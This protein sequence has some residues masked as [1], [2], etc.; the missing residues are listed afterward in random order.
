MQSQRSHLRRFT[1]EQALARLRELDEAESGDGGDSD[2]DEDNDVIQVANCNSSSSDDEQ[3]D[4]PTDAD[5]STSL[6]V[7]T[8]DTS[9]RS[10][11]H[12]SPNCVTSRDGKNGRIYSCNLQRSLLVVFRHSMSFLLILGRLTAET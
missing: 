12:S 1:A 5:F 3:D 9:K 11:L 4:P 10:P 6:R 2:V 7:C 8:S